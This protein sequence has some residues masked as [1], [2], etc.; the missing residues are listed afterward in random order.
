MITNNRYIDVNMDFNRNSF[1][2]D[3]SKS[4]DLSAIQQ[5]VI[6]IVSTGK[7]EKPFDS[8]FGVGVYDLLFEII[9]PEDV[10]NLAS[11]IDRQLR[12]YEPRV[13]FSQVR[14]EQTDYTL[15]L[16]I[17][18]FVNLGSSGQPP[19]QTVKLTLTKVR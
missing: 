11:E 2:N 5:S 12:K 17:D 10:G 1:T 15:E 14:V 6:K 18:Y 8:D 16:E 19:L 4:I 13:E 3:V 7:N 9:Q